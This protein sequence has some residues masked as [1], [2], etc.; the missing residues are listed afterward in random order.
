MAKRKGPAIKKAS[1]V[2]KPRSEGPRVMTKVKNKGNMIKQVKSMNK[3][4]TY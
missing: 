1:S 3:R 2:G 4:L